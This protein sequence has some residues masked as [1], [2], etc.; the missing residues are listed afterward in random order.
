MKGIKLAKGIVI[1]AAGAM[2]TALI[3]G[4]IAAAMIHGGIIPMG[5][6]AYWRDLSATGANPAGADFRQPWGEAV[7]HRDHDLPGG[8]GRRD[9]PIRRK[10]TPPEGTI[11]EKRP[12]K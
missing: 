1:G 10:N 8:H 11:G 6:M 12:E 5:G 9:D 7:D 4:T 2:V 3:L